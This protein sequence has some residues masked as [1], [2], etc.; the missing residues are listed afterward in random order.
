MNKWI[1]DFME[2]KLL[3][4]WHFF[5]ENIIFQKIDKHH[6]DPS[7]AP[8]WN[9]SKTILISWIYCKLRNSLM[10]NYYFLIIIATNYSKWLHLNANI[11]LSVRKSIKIL[12]TF[13]SRSL[14]CAWN[15]L[16]GRV[17]RHPTWQM[18]YEYFKMF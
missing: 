14:Y 18:A 4:H 12:T 3:R 9:H 1:I 8:G 16:R 2:A 13:Q 7:E 11:E 17:S 5:Q 6:K 15:S 10:N